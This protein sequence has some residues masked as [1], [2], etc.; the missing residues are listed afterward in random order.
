MNTWTETNSSKI[1]KYVLAL[2][3]ITLATIVALHQDTQKLLE[4]LQKNGKLSLF[5]SLFLYALLGATPIPSE[6]L[7]LVI[8][9]LF[10][11]LLAA[12][13]ATLGNTL[14]A[15]TEFF[16]GGR[17]GDLSD[18]ERRKTR[19]PFHLDRLPIDSPFFL[20]LG[21]MIPGFGPKFISVVSGVYQVPLWTY[22]WTALVSNALG[23]GMIAFGG[24]GILKLFT[25]RF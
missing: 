10:G 3:L 25:P 4:F 15:L 16:I 20:L 24:Y 13:V 9:T 7:T 17:I 19:L 12:L 5:I 18:F 23:A 2:L 1:W 11:P 6:P 21:R 22:I 14:A 8:V